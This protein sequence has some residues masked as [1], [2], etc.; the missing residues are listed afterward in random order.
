MNLGADA[1]DTV[2]LGGSQVDKIYLGD[3]EVWADIHFQ[4]TVGNNA[5]VMY[6]FSI[7]SSIGAIVPNKFVG[8]NINQLLFYP[9]G[10]DIQF[11]LNSLQVPGVTQVEIG[12]GGFTATLTYDVGGSPNIYSGSS[13]DIIS[14]IVAQDG[15]TVPITLRAL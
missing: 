7:P 6:G 2:K 1:V 13:P 5:N 12:A 8:F 11:D 3:T 15:N 10:D 4:L 14:Y 9:S